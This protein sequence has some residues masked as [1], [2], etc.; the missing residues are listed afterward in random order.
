MF[1]KLSE[2]EPGHVREMMSWFADRRS[3]Q[4]W[5]GPDFR[6]PLVISPAHRNRGAGRALIAELVELGSRTLGTNECSLFVL[7]E[8]P[9]KR[10]YERLGFVRAAYPVDDPH[11]ATLEY[12][13]APVS[14]V[15]R[16]SRSA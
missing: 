16:R 12:M 8:N 10:L 14:E 11:V 5:G 2:L 9:A 4:Q 3:C 1:M 15:L 6:F 7:A 13:V